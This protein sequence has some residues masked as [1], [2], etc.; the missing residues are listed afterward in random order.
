MTQPKE[1]GRRQAAR[2]K[3]QQLREA[4][5]ARQRRRRGLLIACSVVAVLA[6]VLVIGV[7]VQSQRGSTAASAATPANLTDGGVLVGP[8]AAPVTVTTYEDFQ[9]PACKAFETTTGPTLDKLRQAGTVKVVSKPVAILNRFSTDDYSTR[10]M[11]AAGCLVDKAPEAY[12]ALKSALFAQQPEE[13]GPGLKDATLVS[14]AQQAGGPDISGCV[15]DRTYQ[16]WTSRATDQASKDGLQ[17]TP[18]VL[19]NGAPLK[20]T[21]PA[22]L[23]A[24]VQ[25]AQK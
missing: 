11:N 13:N 9:C 4:E 20:D 21:S 19:V 3:A 22:G 8:A 14:L 18:Y 25:A 10:A 6:V 24:A 2:Q 17:G 12:P 15:K 7:V 23:T 5:L 16:G 1:P